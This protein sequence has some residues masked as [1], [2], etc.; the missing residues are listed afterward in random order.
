FSEIDLLRRKAGVPAANMATPLESR[1]GTQAIEGVDDFVNKITPDQVLVGDAKALPDLINKA[2]ETW[3]RMSKSQLIDDAVEAS[4]DYLSGGASGIKNQFARILKS[5]KLSR[6]FSEMEKSAMRRV[7]NG[8][9]PEKVLNLFSGGLGQM[10]TMGMGAGL[11]GLPGFLAGTGIAVGSRK[12]SEA[13]AN[14]NA[15]IVRALVA[16][17]KAGPL[18]QIGQGPRA[19]VEALIRRGAAIGGIE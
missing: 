14:R 17:G 16:S 11:G 3:S 8:T 12:G 10:T 15:E 4:Q 6:G 1:L 7:V 2:R 18:P 5:P 19:V 9:V 13:L